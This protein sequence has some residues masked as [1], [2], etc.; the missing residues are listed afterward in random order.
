MAEFKDNLGPYVLE[1]ALAADRADDSCYVLN[2]GRD[3]NGNVTSSLKHVNAQID[4]YLINVYDRLVPVTKLYVIGEWKSA[5]AKKDS[6]QASAPEEQKRYANEVRGV[7]NDGGDEA[8][9]ITVALVHQVRAELARCR[10][11][12]REAR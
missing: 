5:R 8:N 10:R 7:G 2:V 11:A 12:N 1:T 3:E 9:F 4:D 6:E